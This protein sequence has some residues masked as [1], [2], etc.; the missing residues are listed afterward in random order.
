[1]QKQVSQHKELP[2]STAPVK[3]MTMTYIF[4]RYKLSFTAAGRSQVYSFTSALTV[5]VTPIDT[6]WDINATVKKLH[7]GK[8]SNAYFLFFLL[9]T[10]KATK[11]LPASP[12]SP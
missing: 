3:N 5:K 8:Q 11:A 10:G 9:L 2:G 4:S 12:L 1:M 6:F 7:K